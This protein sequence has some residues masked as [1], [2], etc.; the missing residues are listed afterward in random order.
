MAREG[1]PRVS[2]LDQPG[3]KIWVVSFPLAE[4]A[5]LTAAEQQVALSVARGNTNRQIAEARG[6]SER[7]V[8]NQVASACKKLGAKNRR[9]LAVALARG[10]P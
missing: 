7:T 2:V 8:A 4:H 1:A 9:Q 3:T 5:G 6:T 10:K